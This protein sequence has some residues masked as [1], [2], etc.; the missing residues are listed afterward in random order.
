M[1]AAKSA[2]ENTEKDVRIICENTEKDVR[3]I[4]EN[5]M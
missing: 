5:N 4:C 2:G 3:I 1:G